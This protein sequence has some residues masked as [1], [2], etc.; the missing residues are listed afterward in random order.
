M[1]LFSTL[2]DGTG[3]TPAEDVVDAWLE[4]GIEN[5]GEILEVRHGTAQEKNKNRSDFCFSGFHSFL[6]FISLLSQALN[7][8]L[9]EKVSLCDLAVALENELL[10][11]K[12][13]IHQ[14]ALASFKAEIRHLL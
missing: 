11:T 10:T 7:F 14:A 12:N 6:F 1:C 9:A 8:S 4:E 5:G 3:F 2:D 13:G